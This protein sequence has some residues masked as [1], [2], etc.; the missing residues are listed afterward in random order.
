MLAAMLLVVHVFAVSAYTL[1]VRKVA[2]EGV[3]KF[4]LGAISQTGFLLVTYVVIVAGRVE[5]D[6]SLTL[7][8]LALIMLSALFIVSLNIFRTH[9]LR[10]VE[11]S[12]FPI[13]F[14]LRLLL[15]TVLG[16]VFLG[17]SPPALQTIGGL[18]IFGS[19][20]E[21]SLNRK[22]AHIHKGM[23]WGVY[24]AA[25]FSFH[26]V[27]EKYNIDRNGL[28][29]YMFWVGTIAT[30]IAW[31]VLY[32]SRRRQPLEPFRRY[33]QPQMLGAILFPIVSGWTYVAS[34]S[35]FQVAVVNYIS[36][37]SVVVSVITGVFFLGERQH[38]CQKGAAAV[39]AV[40]GLTFILI[41]NI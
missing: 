39:L 9:A 11:A 20:L 37:L 14:N 34:L 24:M 2:V 22:N 3:N 25:L 10:H 6:F 29:T 35:H 16:L 38:L 18:I 28:G 13:V 5:A 19:I 21:I 41:G 7:S 12:V 30:P 26:A 32:A 17:E 36:G 31:L 33:V 8:E 40:V 23:E 15:L 4:Q 27:L 1:Y